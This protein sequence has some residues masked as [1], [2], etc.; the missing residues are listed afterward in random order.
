MADGLPAMYA[1]VAL[2][3]ETK[4]QYFQIEW[5]EHPEW[6]ETAERLARELWQDWYPTI[7]YSNVVLPARTSSDISLPNSGEDTI[8]ISPWKQK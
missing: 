8:V 6:I 2:D 5:K 1:T 4:L 7:S 3:P